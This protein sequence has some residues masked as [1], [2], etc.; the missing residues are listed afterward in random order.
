MS[1]PT[2]TESSSSLWQNVV[3][4]FSVAD[5]S[6]RAFLIAPSTERVKAVRHALHKAKEREAAL[7]V[8]QR[9]SPQEQMDLFPD[10]VRLA[11]CGHGHVQMVRSAIKAL[12]R[13]WVLARIEAAAEPLLIASTEQF[14]YEEFR[15]L[16]ELYEQL[17]NEELLARLA[18]RALEHDDEDVREAGQDFLARLG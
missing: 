7:Q 8:L 10:L 3:R 1:L 13:D 4:D 16:L 14:Q 6:L 12:P 17:G 2:H 18:Q 15:R 9:M 5:A 11:S